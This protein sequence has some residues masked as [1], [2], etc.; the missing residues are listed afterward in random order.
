MFTHEEKYSKKHPIFYRNSDNFNRSI[1]SDLRFIISH[2]KSGSAIIRSK[3]IDYSIDAPMLLLVSEKCNL[4]VIDSEDAVFNS[5][6]FHPKYTNNKLD[7][8]HIRGDRTG[9][10][11]TDKQD[12]YQLDI[13][14]HN[15]DDFQIVELNSFNNS[16]INS[17]LDSI[18]VKLIKQDIETWPCMSRLILMNM[19][20]FIKGMEQKN[21]QEYKVVIP[22]SECNL[23]DVIQYLHVNYSRDLN[24][25]VLAN[26]FGTNRTSLNDKFKEEYNTTIIKYLRQVRIEKSLKLLIDTGLSVTEVAYDVGF[27][28]V[29]NF[30]RSFKAIMSCTPGQYRS[31]KTEL[32][33]E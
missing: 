16:Q 2:L 25:Q 7:F 26:K 4:E 23:H 13:F 12:L 20:F 6:Y 19:I 21:G 28:D 30:G 22:N 8:S 1:D 18:A 32:V 17:F 14:S 9:L 24:V 11:H 31:S 33:T 5:L 3:G 27:K 29:T 15:D 10:C